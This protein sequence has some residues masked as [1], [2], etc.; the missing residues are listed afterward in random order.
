[1][2]ERKSIQRLNGELIVFFNAT[3]KL[4]DAWWSADDQVPEDLPVL[5]DE[6]A[7]VYDDLGTIRRQTP[8]GL[9][10]GSIG[11]LFGAA[12]QGKLPKL[13]SA[14]MLRLGADVAVRADGEI[15]T[16]HRA[17]NPDDRIALAEL[18]AALAA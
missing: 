10:P 6:T 2:E 14:D 5:A 7:A 3:A 13:T 4:V 18:V 17:R 11:A 8:L 1:V 15:A 12:A 9:V 16:L